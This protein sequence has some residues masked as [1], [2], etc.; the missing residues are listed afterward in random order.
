MKYAKPLKT[1]NGAALVLG[2]ILLVAATIL[3]VA[4]MSGSIIQER[5][6]S[7]TYNKE[8]ARIAAETGAATIWQDW[9]EGADDLDEWSA[10]QADKVNN[11]PWHINPGYV[12]GKRGI[13]N[14][15]NIAPFL[16]GN[17]IYW[18]DDSSIVFDTDSNVTMVV[19]GGVTNDD[20]GELLASA[21]V[22]ISFAAPQA[23]ESSDISPWD[24]GVVGCDGV[25]MV[26]SGQ[27]DSFNSN[28]S[29]YNGSFTDAEG[30][31][32]VNALRTNA[33]V[34]TISD[35]ATA[36]LSGNAPIYGDL[37]FT[38]SHLNMQSGTPV[39]GD[40]RAQG[41]VTANGTIHGSLQSGG[42]VIFG[43]AATQYGNASIAGNVTSS[44]NVHGT[45]VAGGDASFTS[46]S[47][48]GGAVTSGGNVDI[49]ATGNPPLAI[50]ANGTVSWPDWWQWDATKMDLVENYI[51]G[52]GVAPDT[53]GLGNVY[54]S[55]E[56]CDLIG[57]LNDQG[58]LGPM[59][60]TAINNPNAQSINEYLPSNGFNEN[61]NS[62]ALSGPGGQDSSRTLGTAGEETVLTVNKDLTTQGNLNDIN[63]QGD[64][65]LVVDGDFD[66]GNNTQLNIAEDATLTILVTGKTTLS[67]G[68]NLLGSS[69]QFT[70]GEGEDTKPAVQI[71][72]T[73]QDN[74]HNQPGVFV[75]GANNSSVAVYAPYT[76]ARIVGS[77]SIFGSVRAKYVDIRGSGDI[78]FDEAL[79]DITQGGG[80]DDSDPVPAGISGWYEVSDLNLLA[81]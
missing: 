5:M 6:T 38:G 10:W 27:V 69:H 40:V 73:Y 66:L 52:T 64:V 54:N 63:I 55:D 2:L 48:Q 67:G 23:G 35:N 16:N 46:A 11:R 28:Y 9:I 76:A 61:K 58:E 59:F 34:R 26:G 20:Q 53:S 30:N 60:Q 41:D 68:S 7:N 62:I 42:N 71:F 74:N 65:T 1:Q 43:N 8:I 37:V 24:N 56:V 57:L 32:G 51:A 78:H 4:S 81:N 39:Y 79:A 44:G 13:P 70:R 50:S 36:S 29:A 49:G 80:A 75:G 25:N 77:G 72:S 15:K 45:I 17:S 22:V 21:S 19:H 14:G 47:N 31:I 3:T 12:N 33:T 18:V